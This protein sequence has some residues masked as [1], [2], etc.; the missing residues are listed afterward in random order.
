MSERRPQPNIIRDMLGPS[1][2]EDR[3]EWALRRIELKGTER[4]RDEWVAKAAALDP[5]YRDDYSELWGIW[6][7]LNRAEAED[8]SEGQIRSLVQDYV[9]RREAGPTSP[10][11]L[12]DAA[13]AYVAALKQVASHQ[14]KRPDPIAR[15]EEAEAA[16]AEHGSE[17]K[18]AHALGI[19]KTQLRRL[20]GK[21]A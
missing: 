5:R 2:P 16:Y 17:R 20:L 10:L 11:R 14:R 7:R 4:R 15:P 6:S 18:A 3:R 21:D 1:D 9:L 12:E 19:S 13:I 8:W